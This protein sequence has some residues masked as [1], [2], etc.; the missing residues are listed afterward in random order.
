MNTKVYFT[1]VL[2]VV[3][4]AFIGGMFLE[5]ST[6][7]MQLLT[8]SELADYPSLVPVTTVEESIEHNSQASGKQDRLLI[9]GEFNVNY[10]NGNFSV[11][12]IKANFNQVL[13]SIAWELNATYRS[14]K[15]DDEVVTV[16]IQDAGIFEVLTILLQNT[17]YDFG[18][19]PIS[20]ESEEP[21]RQLIVGNEVSFFRDTPKKNLS[22]TEP[23]DP[24]QT[25]A[26][27]DNDT[28]PFSSS[29]YDW[30]K[31]SDADSRIG[32]IENLDIEKSG[33]E[34]IQ[35]V[36]VDDPDPLVRL[37]ALDALDGEDTFIARKILLSLLE[38]NNPDIVVSALEKIVE[39]QDVSIMSFLEPLRNRPESQI[40]AALQQA[41]F[42]LE[43]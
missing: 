12:A 11:T 35:A 28:E 3:I 39:W 43:D 10:S 22:S 4:I 15:S 2:C 19:Y 13:E 8:S 32:F 20:V 5:K 30:L 23:N 16:N 38:D 31:T 14:D 9:E 36:V 42:Y 33:Y 18:F 17:Y 37:A 27:Y 7:V 26:K 29:E 34:L 41:L 1:G 24:Q 40:H 6:K 25:W 21:I